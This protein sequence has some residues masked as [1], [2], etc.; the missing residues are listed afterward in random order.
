VTDR[1]LAADYPPDSLLISF[2]IEWL[3]ITV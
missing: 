2:Q 3:T 1:L